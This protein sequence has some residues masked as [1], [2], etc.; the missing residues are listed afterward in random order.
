[1][2]TTFYPRPHTKILTEFGNGMITLTQ[3]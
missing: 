2:G 3:H 1:M